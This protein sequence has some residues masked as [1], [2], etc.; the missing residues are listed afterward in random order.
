MGRK[1]WHSVDR[2]LLSPGYNC[3][4]IPSCDWESSRM[5]LVPCFP[6]AVLMLIAPSMPLKP[7]PTPQLLSFRT[8]IFLLTT[9]NGQFD[10][11]DLCQPAVKSA[12]W[13][14]DTPCWPWAT[15]LQ[16][17][18]FHHRVVADTQPTPTSTTS[19]APRVGCLLEKLDEHLNIIP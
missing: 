15:V 19:L 11:L 4:S 2:Q 7:I 6:E 18:G 1:P 12:I 10:V 17:A 3:L 8:H 9:G 13:G 14:W 5:T 16:H